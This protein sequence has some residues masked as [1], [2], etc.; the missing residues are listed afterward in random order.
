MKFD[1]DDEIAKRYRVEE[2]LS[3]PSSKTREFLRHST[4]GGKQLWTF[5]F[6]LTPNTPTSQ[7]LHFH[8]GFHAAGAP[9]Q[10]DRWVSLVSPCGFL[11]SSRMLTMHALM[12]VLQMT[13]EA[14]DIVKL[15]LFARV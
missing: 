4:Q 9:F 10:P 1:K 13:P 15:G 8:C 5:A 14:F 11:E 7:A 2:T 12:A 6:T 3:W